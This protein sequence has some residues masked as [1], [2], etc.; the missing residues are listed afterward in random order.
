MKRITIPILRACVAIVAI[1]A[2]IG[3]L[4][5]RPAR[6]AAAPF[7]F[8]QLSDP[9]FGMYTANAD[10]AQ[11]TANFT[12]A[13]AAAN[14]LRPAFVVVTGDLVNKAGDAAQIG[15]YRRVAATLDRAIPLYHVAGNH[16]VENTPTPQTIAAYTAQFGPDHYA[17]DAGNVRGIVLDS[18]LIA[19]PQQAREAF[20][21]QERWLRAELARARADGV[22]HIVVF[23]HHP[24]FLLHPG[25]PDDYF[26]IP[27]ARR[28]PYLKLLEESGVQYLFA[29][30][31]HRSLLA[32]AGAMEMII[33][34]PVGKPLGDA[35]SGLRIAIVDDA[36]IT[37]RYYDFGDVPNHI[38][39]TKGFQSGQGSQT[40]SPTP[41]RP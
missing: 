21:E 36:G 12:F 29:G 30:H 7:F 5:A 10:F 34:G 39:V 13:I 37:H 24:W 16:D 9:Q 31:Y 25:E 38:A 11:E 18:S 2:S 28:T 27:L 17:F 35:K 14:R 15:E 4:L 40:A 26:N 19:A 6:A 23:Q 32:R 1:S 8:I 22:R 3:V 33:T 20:D 41:V